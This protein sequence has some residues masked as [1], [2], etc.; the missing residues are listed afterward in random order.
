MS[1]IAQA[2]DFNACKIVINGKCERKRKQSL[3]DRFNRTVSRRLNRL[4]DKG[5]ISISDLNDW[6]DN[7][8]ALRRVSRNEKR[9]NRLD[10]VFII[11]IVMIAT[12]SEQRAKALIRLAG[13]HLSDYYNDERT[14]NS[15]A[16][17]MLVYQ[18]EYTIK[19]RMELYRDNKDKI[20][21]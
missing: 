18:K 17:L 1:Q 11:G 16:L 10:L 5:I 2:L 9:K 20:G 15:L 19:E 14:K 4:I 3:F 21:K 7:S 13:Y 6:L 8:E 12:K